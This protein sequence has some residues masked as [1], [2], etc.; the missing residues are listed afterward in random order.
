MVE[1]RQSRMTRSVRV[2]GL[3][4][5]VFGIAA[6]H[7][8][9]FCVGGETHD[10]MSG[11]M[12]AAAS[13]V[14][15]HPVSGPAHGAVHACTFVLSRSVPDIGPVPGVREEAGADR[16]APILGGLVPNHR[17]RPPPWT[18]PSLAELSILRI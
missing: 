12:V 11:R 7:A 8:G 15:V 3:L 14:A 18:M 5:L 1:Q 10:G 17:G 2:L 13:E 16:P 4:L 9:V 6:M